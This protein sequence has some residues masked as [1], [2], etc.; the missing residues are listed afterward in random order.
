M[1]SKSCV[2]C[3]TDKKIFLKSSFYIKDIFPRANNHYLLCP[4]KHIMDLKIISR[5]D[6]T[7]LMLDLFSFVETFCQNKDFKIEINNG[8]LAGQQ[9]FHLHI[10]ILWN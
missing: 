4:K 3:N 2:F 10:H 1:N 5:E 9:I 7:N 8:L 6:Y